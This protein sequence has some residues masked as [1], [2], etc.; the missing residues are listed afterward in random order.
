[1]ERIS[2][3]PYDIKEYIWNMKKTE[4]EDIS[5]IF[6]TEIRNKWWKYCNCVDC[7]ARRA[8]FNYFVD[9]Y[10]ESF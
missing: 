9:G 8:R 1:M 2:N 10:F 4:I 6:E 3:L 7:S 5:N